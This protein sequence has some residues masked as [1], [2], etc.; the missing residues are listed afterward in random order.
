MTIAIRAGLAEPRHFEEIG[1][2]SPGLGPDRISDI[3]TRLILG[4]LAAYTER[5]CRDLGIETR[6]YRL[7]EY[8]EGNPTAIRVRLPVNPKSDTRDGIVLVPKDL[9]RRL[10]TISRD[11]FVDYLWQ[12]HSADLRERFNVAV[13]RDL[14]GKV[15]ALANANDPHCRDR[16]GDW[17]RSFIDGTDGSAVIVA[18]GTDG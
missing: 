2:L 7:W 6:H 13:K 9:L 16:G 8:R 11:G 14:S 18:T 3:S 5:V 15:L 1:L 4:R 17:G 12:F 10:P